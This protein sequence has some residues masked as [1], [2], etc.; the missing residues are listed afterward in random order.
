MTRFAPAAWL[1]AACLSLAPAIAVFLPPRLKDY[2]VPETPLDM[3][4]PMQAR[5]W[6]FLRQAW[7]EMP[8]S[9][10]YAVRAPNLH[11]EMSIYMMSLGMFPDSAAR[12]GS[13]FGIPRPGGADDAQVL[14]CL[15][16]LDPAPAGFDC[17]H[18][19]EGCI[20]GRPAS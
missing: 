12:A 14:L 10:V 1:L 9:V 6:K 2:H 18:V 15:P 3:I 13:Y 4:A 17:K 20:C 16:C 8:R 11:D 19:G 7:V 5:Q